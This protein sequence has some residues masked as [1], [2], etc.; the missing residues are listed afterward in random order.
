MRTG[1]WPVFQAKPLAPRRTL[2]TAALVRAPAPSSSIPASKLLIPYVTPFPAWAFSVPDDRLFA[3][4]PLPG[5]R[6]SRLVSQKLCRQHQLG[7]SR[8]WHA[9]RRNHWRQHVWCCQEDQALQR[10]S[11]RLAGLWNQ[12]RCCLITQSFFSFPSYFFSFCQGETP[13]L[14]SDLF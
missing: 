6:W 3:D 1:V 12:V 13:K 11:S 2:T 10:Q 9:R 5:F 4:P 8:P 7:R 14:T